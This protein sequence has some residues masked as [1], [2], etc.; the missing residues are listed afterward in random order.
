MRTLI[1]YRSKYGTTESCAGKIA[2]G[3]GEGGGHK[4]VLM[5]LKE[6]PGNNL[7]PYDTV[8]IGSPIYGGLIHPAVSRFCR[9]Y[10]THLLGRP[11]ALF[12]CGLDRGERA[13]SQIRTAYPPW[14]TLHAFTRHHLGGSLHPRSL[15]P[16]DRLLFRL[17]KLQPSGSSRVRDEEIQKLTNLVISQS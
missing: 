10:R 13:E 15:H 5:N 9:K 4:A 8:V 7:E 16:G 12:V 11:V 14:L 6:K 1:V 17:L 2:E 3:L